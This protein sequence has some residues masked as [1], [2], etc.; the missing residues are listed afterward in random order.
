M[1]FGDAAGADQEVGREAEHGDAQQF[2]SARFAPDEAAHRLHRRQRVVGRQRDERAV[3][4][5]CDER[6]DAGQAE[7]PPTVPPTVS[8]SM[9][10]VGW[11]TPTGT[12]WPSLPQVPMPVSS[13][14][15]L[16][17][18]ETRVSASGP[19]PMSVAPLT[20]WVTWPFSMR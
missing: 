9:R 14:R 5:A 11:P 15:S 3:R 20:G 2:Q 12:L 4:D 17:I 1:H 18:I 7:F 16:P 13:A 10:S 6:L 8:A 19:L